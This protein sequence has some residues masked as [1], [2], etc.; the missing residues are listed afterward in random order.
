MT[1]QHTTILVSKT[2]LP[3]DG[4]TVSRRF[5][6]GNTQSRTH[7]RRVLKITSA[8]TSQQV[9][10][11][12]NK[13]CYL[14]RNINIPPVNLIFIKYA[15]RKTTTRTTT[16][17]ARYFFGNNLKLLSRIATNILYRYVFKKTNKKKSHHHLLTIIWLVQFVLH[18]VI[19]KFDCT[20]SPTERSCE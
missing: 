14:W 2:T 19:S 11:P 13:P 8:S 9:D 6:L 16:R 4:L 10:V 7:G 5:H 1:S 18:E 17:T 15:T 12:T 20:I 3:P